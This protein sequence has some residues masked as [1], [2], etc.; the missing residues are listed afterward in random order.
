MTR[1]S[2]LALCAC[3]GTKQP[4]V[5]D[6]RLTVSDGSGSAAV[7]PIDAPPAPEAKPPTTGDIN[8]R[9]QW[10]KMPRDARVSPG[11]S[12]C[13]TPLTAQVSPST[14]WGIGD[15]VVFVEGAPARS[16]GEA[17]IVAAKCS[18]LP[19][20]AVGA[21]LALASGGDRPV[22]LS[23]AH[24]INAAD[25]AT[26]S[27]PARAVSLPIAGHEVSTVLTAG[28]IYHLAFDDKDKGDDAWI[29][30]ADAIITDAS[31]GV[32]IKD[33]A[34]G[35]HEIRAWLPPRGKLPAHTATGKVDVAAGELAELTLSFD[36]TAAKQTNGERGDGAP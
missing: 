25:L 18:L 26:A 31:G 4:H 7:A 8:V 30:S 36:P 20:V 12:S 3:S 13:N 9:V 15:V 27:E 21:S 22:K 2:L 17:R 6:A 23:L 19:R 34:P 33:V 16:V 35:T 29:V 1:F 5:D 28:G 24:E 14:T 10:A 32:L 11:I